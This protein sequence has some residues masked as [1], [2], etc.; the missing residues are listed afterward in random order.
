MFAK[1]LNSYDPLSWAIKPNTLLHQHCNT[2]ERVIAWEPNLT[3]PLPWLEYTPCR[4]CSAAQ[5]CLTLCNPMDCSMPGLPVCHY[6]LEF[7]Q[8][9]VHWVDDAMQTP[10]PLL[11]PSPPALNLSQHQALLHW[12]SSSPQVSKGLELQLQQQPFQWIFRT[13]FLSIFR[14]DWFDLFAVRGTQES[15]PTPQFES[16][17]SSAPSLLYGPAL[18]SIHECWKNHSFD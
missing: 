10:H 11:P 7:A 8:A 4:C 13:Y 12:V 2:R 15:S 3:G 16:I 17:H 14:I 18:T 5:S 6:R 9:H 1:L